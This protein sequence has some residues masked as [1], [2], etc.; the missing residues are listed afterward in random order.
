VPQRPKR[1]SI[2]GRRRGGGHEPLQEFAISG[3][4]TPEILLKNK[5]IN[6]AI[7]SLTLTA[8]RKEKGNREAAGNRGAMTI[9]REEQ[10]QT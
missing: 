10:K 7:L 9:G 5:K 3:A 2:L 8:G 1:A 6:S 4:S